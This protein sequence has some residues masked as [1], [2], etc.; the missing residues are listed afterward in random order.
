MKTSTRLIT[1]GSLESLALAPEGLRTRARFHPTIAVLVGALLGGCGDKR[2]A[3]GAEAPAM[4]AK[5]AL[6][7]AEKLVPSI[8]AQ[9][10]EALKGKLSFVAHVGDKDR[11]VA[12]QPKGWTGDQLGVRP[13]VRDLGFMTRFAVDSNCDGEC[14][15]KDWA[16][17]ADRVD[18]AQLV[19]GDFTVVK[20]EPTPTGRLVVAKSNDKTFVVSASWR[21]GSARYFTC[22]VVLDGEIQAAAPAF[23]AAC[24]ATQVLSWR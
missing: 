23:E 18:F 3:A 12:I 24:R 9:V 1:R 13:P 15:A 5:A 10:P 6:A 20:D 19:K 8:D 17:V 14:M 22:H 16:K 7:A 2:P 21:E 4:D 11:V